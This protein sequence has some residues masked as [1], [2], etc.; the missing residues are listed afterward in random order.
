MAY[1]F[2]GNALAS[3]IS[4]IVYFK[5]EM[6]EGNFDEDLKCKGCID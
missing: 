6:G 5:Y 1:T 3:T 2:K 4:F